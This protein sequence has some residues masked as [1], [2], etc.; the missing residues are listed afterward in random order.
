MLNWIQVVHKRRARQQPAQRPAGQ[1]G[2]QQGP[3][4]R[5]RRP[6]AFVLAQSVDVNGLVRLHPPAR[7][8]ARRPLRA[9]S[10]A[11]TR[12]RYGATGLEPTY[13]G[14]LTGQT[15]AQQVRGFADL[16]NPRPAGRQ[17]HRH[18][19]QATCRQVAQQ[20]L[21]D[22]AGSVVALDPRTGALLAFWSYPSYDP[23][24]ISSLDGARC[25][26]GLERRQRRARQAAAGPPVPGALPAG[27]DVQDR[28]RLDRGAGRR[29][30]RRPTRLSRRPAATCPPRPT[31][32]AISNFGGEVVWRHPDPDPR[33]LVQL[34]LRPDGHRDHRWPD[35]MVAGAQAFGFNQTPPIDL[36]GAAASRFP[37]ERSCAPTR[38]TSRRWPRRRSARTATPATPLQMAL[39][40]SAIADGGMI[41]K[42][43]VMKEIRDSEGNVIERYARQPVAAA[44]QPETAADDARRHDVGGRPRHRHGAADARLRRRRQDGHGP[45]RAPTADRRL[46]DRVR[47]PGRPGAHDRGRRSWCSTSPACS[48]AT[49]A[50]VAGPIAKQVLEAYLNGV[51]AAGH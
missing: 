47:R 7:L 33:G 5:S 15:V 39:V 36:P 51:H 28:D 8:P 23:N 1:A 46:D 13:D 38:P 31:T 20:A 19:A 26:G 18:G 27:L 34:G 9:S 41:M 43:H 4:A 29:G 37:T 2:V 49:G 14:E 30:H 12:S 10:P 32:N 35:E 21:G 6:T 40:A 48:E 44:D 11:S 42:P 24:P 25:Q 45:D 22:R 50:R 17:P 3:R 16:L